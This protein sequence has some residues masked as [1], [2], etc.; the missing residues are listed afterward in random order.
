MQEGAQVVEVLDGQRPVQTL[1]VVE[2]GDLLGR[3]L[4]AEDAACGTSGQRVQQTEDHDRDDEDHG[5]RL[6]EPPGEVQRGLHGQLLHF[7][8]AGWKLAR[9]SW[10]KP[11]R[12]PRMT[13]IW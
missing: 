7:H 3:G 8:C 10:E 5:Q 6:Q 11:P 12:P 2:R 4:R 13:E 9:E 1:V